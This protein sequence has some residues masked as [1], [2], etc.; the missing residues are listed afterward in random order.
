MNVF[1]HCIRVGWPCAAIPVTV[2][3][4]FNSTCMYSLLDNVLVHQ[5]EAA[6]YSLPL[7]ATP[8]DP[9]SLESAM[10]PFSTPR[11]DLQPYNYRIIC[12]SS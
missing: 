12:L 3:N 7:V 11:E 2:A 6:L 9:V 10:V 1:V 5:A 4:S 8:E